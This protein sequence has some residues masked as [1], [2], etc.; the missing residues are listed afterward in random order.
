MTD[1]NHKMIND[2]TLCPHRCHID[3]TK[4]SGYCGC[5]DRLRVARAALHHGEE[6][7]ISGDR[8]AGAIFFSGCTLRCRFCQN[9]SISHH[10]I[11]RD[12]TVERLAAIFANLES[13]N[14]A[15][16]DLVT[17][18]QWS[19]HIH[20]ALQIYRPNI[21]IVYNCSGY[22]SVDTLKILDKDIDIYLPDFKYADRDIAYNYSKVK[23]YKDIVCDAISE[24]IRQVGRP[25]FDDDGYMKKGIIIRH[26]ILPLHTK[27][28]IDVL[29]IIK[30]NFGTDIW[31]SLMSQ[32]TPMHKDDIFPEL[33][34][35]LTDR[36]IKKVYNSA[37]DMG[38]HNG[39][40]QDKKSTGIEA[41]PIFDMTGV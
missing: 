34:R 10:M 39:Y 2:C 15:N 21:P 11:G 31:I 3:R 37:I 28:S 36:E 6:P 29:R 19:I 18:S 17:P 22:E 24:M 4:S 20:D 16:I 38:F 27:N 30:E 41:I 33:S 9:E 26:M 32:Y 1:I 7:C 35:H 40:M 12:I 13:D 23:D 8:G 14:A 25:I 5:S